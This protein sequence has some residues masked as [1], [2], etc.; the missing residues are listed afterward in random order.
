[1]MIIFI[2]RWP[3][4]TFSR[5][6]TTR[7]SVTRCTILNPSLLHLPRSFF[8]R[9]QFYGPKNSTKNLRKVFL[10]HKIA[11]NGVFYSSLI[12]IM[13]KKNHEWFFWFL[14]LK[15][16]KC[17]FLHAKL[18]EL[19]TIALSSSPSQLVLSKAELPAELEPTGWTTYQKR[20][21]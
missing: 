8:S 14:K 2:W 9:P 15:D 21:T 1:M 19:C 17:L 16:L 3:A 10:N 11:Q 7:T 13:F 4:S 18:L 12:R 5:V 20:Q 6:R